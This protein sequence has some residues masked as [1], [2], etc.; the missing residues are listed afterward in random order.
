M[1][2]TGRDRKIIAGLVVLVLLAGYWFLLFSPKREEVAQVQEEVATQQQRL[3]SAH[4]EVARLEQAQ[5]TYAADYSS[6]VH[7]GKAIPET[8]DS[9]SL[10]IQLQDAADGTGIEFDAITAGD[11]AP[12]AA[13]APA[14]PQSL[15]KAASEE[16]GQVAPGTQPASSDPEG[17]AGE[18]AAGREDTP[19][20]RDAADGAAQAETP[21]ALEGVPLTFKF[22]G[23]FYGLADF[24]HRVKRFVRVAG[25]D[26]EISGRLLTIDKLT[27]KAESDFPNVKAELGATAY[28]TP[29][30]TGPTGGATEAGPAV[31]ASRSADGATAPST[32]AA[33]VT[34]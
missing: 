33:A 6:V 11:R 13:A 24:F 28:V 2:I 8:V 17:P 10:L 21:G 30:A 15:G 18:V 31:P 16:T 19:A 20:A 32:P 7:L 14:A 27:M 34:R 12:V 9:A 4:A 29:K 26:I 5:T 3:D 22:K 1:S 25:D 23:S